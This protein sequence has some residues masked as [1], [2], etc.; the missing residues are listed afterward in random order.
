[1]YAG[2][3]GGFEQINPATGTAIG[4]PVLVPSQFIAGITRTPCRRSA[5]R[6]HRGFRKYRYDERRRAPFTPSANGFTFARSFW[7][8]NCHHPDDA[9]YGLAVDRNN[10]V[11]VSTDATARSTSFRSLERKRSAS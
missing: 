1:M 2:I 6:L 3:A 5:D 11:Y 9:I 8:G 10:V 4:S 7:T